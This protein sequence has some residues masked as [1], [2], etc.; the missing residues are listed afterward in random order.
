MGIVRSLLKPVSSFF[1]M[2]KFEHTV[3]ALP[4][5]YMGMFLAQEGMPPLRTVLL[6]TLAFASARAYAMTL[7]R[8]IDLPFDR[9]NPRTKDRALVTGRIGVKT[10]V[11]CVLISLVLLIFSAWKLG[12]L[13]LKLLPIALFFLSFYHLTKRFTYLSHFFLGF[14]DG[15][16]PAGSWI[17]VRSSFLSSSDLPMW[18]LVFVVTSWIAGFDILYQCQD[19]EFDRKEGLHSIPARFGIPFALQTAK[20]CHL[21][22]MILLFCLSYFLSFRLPFIASLLLTAL[23]LV[24]EHS[25]LSPFDPLRLNV[26]F[27]NMNGYISAVVCSGIVCSLLLR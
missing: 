2:I 9:K 7:N 15:L 16:A 10:A 21:C 26:A 19:V 18:L 22:M 20:F 25:I 13:C 24:K 3:F 17:A 27:F 1:E 8:L 6:V 4:F 5:A 11:L 14:T 12:P 23:L